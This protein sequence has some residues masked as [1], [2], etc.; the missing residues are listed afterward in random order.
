[1]RIAVIC[2]VHRKLTALEAVIADL[3]ETGADGGAR[4]QPGGRIEMRR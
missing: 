1:M 4:R 2:D 3:E